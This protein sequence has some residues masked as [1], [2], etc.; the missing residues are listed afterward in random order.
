MKKVEK[1]SAKETVDPDILEKRININW[2]ES[3]EVITGYLCNLKPYKAK[4]E[5]NTETSCLLLYFI[6]EKGELYKTVFNSEPYFYVL[7]KSDIIL[8]EMI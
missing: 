3:G 1:K 8:Y 5:Q 7:V 2:V 4:E 6:D